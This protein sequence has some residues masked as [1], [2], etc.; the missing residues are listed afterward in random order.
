[1]LVWRG[2]DPCGSEGTCVEQKGPMGQ[3]G[4]AGSALKALST[5]A[6]GLVD[7]VFG[8]FL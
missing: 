5:P 7:F 3:L 4:E 6:Y 8:S 1:M 2:R